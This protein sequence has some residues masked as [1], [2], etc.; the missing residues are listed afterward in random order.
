MRHGGR[1]VN[2]GSLGS[3]GCALVLVGFMQGRWVHWSAPSCLS[4]SCGVAELIVVRPGDRLFHTG[5][6]GSLGC[7]LGV[8][9]F[10]WLKM[11]CALGVLSFVYGHWLISMP[12]GCR[13]V[14]AVSLG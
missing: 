7:A 2:Q 6:L 10:V 1:R 4:G 3:F 5:S 13:R 12:R 11:G 9:G 8:V 14:R